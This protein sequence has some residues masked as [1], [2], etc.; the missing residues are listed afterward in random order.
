MTDF[1]SLIEPVAKILLGEPNKH[2]SKKDQL[3]YGSHGSLAID[4]KNGCWFDH[5]NG[6]GGGVLELIERET[7]CRG[8]ESCV[9]WLVDKKLIEKPNGGNLGE[10]VATY[11][12]VDENGAL[13]FQVCRFDPKTFRQ[14]QPD[15][16]KRDG[17]NWSVKGVRKVPYRLPG[18]LERIALGHTIVIVEGEKDCNALWQLGLPATCN[19]EGAGKWKAAFNKHFQN[20]DVVLIP[21]ND[22]AG[23]DHVADVAQTLADVAARV[24]VLDLARHWPEMPPKGDVSDWLA[25]GHSRDE[26]ETLFDQ[27]PPY[28]RQPE[29]EPL[30]PESPRV[31]P[32][33]LNQC[34]KIFRKWLGK[35]Y[36]L[37]TIDAVMSVAAVEK[38]SGDPVWLMVI[39]G[40]GNAKTE[41]VQATSKIGAHIV[42]TISS[43]GALLSASPRK[44]HSKGATGG[45]LREIGKHG[46]LVIKDVTSI[47][48]Q[49]RNVRT[50]VLA[51]LREIHDGR[52]VR[53]V[54][55]DGGRRHEW[56]GRLTV[57]G[58]CT[59]AWD[60]AHAVVAEMGDR[61]IYIRPD[62][63]SD[64]SRMDSGG[65][66]LDNVGQEDVMRR[67]LAE[68]VAGVLQGMKVA[69]CEV[70]KGKKKRI[71]EISNLLTRART[72]IERDY[73]G[74][75]ID[76]HDP[77]MPTRFAKQLI[78][79]M[80]GGLAIGMSRDAAMQLIV[81]CAWDSVPKLRLCVLRDL[82]RHADSNVT[83]IRKRL[84]KPRF[85]VDQTLRALHTLGLL[86]CREKEVIRGSRTEWIRD[87]SLAP[88]VD[89]ALLK[90]VSGK[91]S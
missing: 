42:S 74:N 19:A 46:L 56:E 68:A 16:S 77:E 23:R 53:S 60:A 38:L 62:S 50:E 12:Y 2:L 37:D 52:W 87:Y 70:S 34:H 61:F 44:Q 25:L 7:E 5:E 76:A 13:L 80:R 1:A 9:G 49:E 35:T 85:T 86:T 48:S 71:L 26:L 47:L 6:K 31:A 82:A 32:C 41:T 78:Q 15:P 29:A 67:E 30:S 84:R 65:H 54:G 81:R 66:A 58:A 20:A 8:R 36:D 89:P 14:R 40:S 69:A 57:I 79:I 72:A 10:I 21:D 18:C 88:R 64:I 59:T 24:R 63:G 27:A 33:S 83:A 39:S 55:V 73:R 3:R 22:D 51:A 75:V 45:L 90:S 4:I 91:V 28:Q 17:W 11:D 43:P